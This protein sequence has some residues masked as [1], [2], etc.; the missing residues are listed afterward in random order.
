ML[1]VSEE[2]LIYKK[3]KKDENVYFRSV[4][5]LMYKEYKAD[6][7]DAEIT[8]TREQLHVIWVNCGG[9]LTYI[10]YD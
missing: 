1:I 9:F 3:R 6:E 8:G 7:Y 10:L 2:L 4:L 5:Y